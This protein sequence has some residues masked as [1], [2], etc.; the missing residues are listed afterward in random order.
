MYKKELIQYFPL[1]DQSQNKPE[2]RCVFTRTYTL[3]V[4]PENLLVVIFIWTGL[5][6][7]S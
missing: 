5:L 3:D 1:V 7:L 4:D 6:I 2:K